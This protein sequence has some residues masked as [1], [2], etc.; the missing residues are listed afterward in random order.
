[1]AA[2]GNGSG[3]LM[4]PSIVMR[5]FSDAVSP[6]A[7]EWVSVQQ[8]AP[9]KGQSVVMLSRDS[10]PWVGVYQGDGKAH[11]WSSFYELEVPG[12]THWFPM[13]DTKGVSQRHP[14]KN[15]KG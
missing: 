7:P 4:F 2:K 6:D 13:P 5:V 8:I 14:R 11:R 10:G 1:M 12:V 15:L 3:T 9:A